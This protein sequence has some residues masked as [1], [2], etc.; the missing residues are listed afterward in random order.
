MTEVAYAELLDSVNK[1][2]DAVVDRTALQDFA[3]GRSD[4]ELRLWQQAG[5]LGWLGGEATGA[6]LP[7]FLTALGAGLFFMADSRCSLRFHESSCQ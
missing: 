1:V 7:R 5:E 2:L 4:L 3:N 6:L